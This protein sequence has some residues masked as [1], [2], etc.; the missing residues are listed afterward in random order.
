MKLP[1][2][3]PD[4]LLFNVWLG[5]KQALEFNTEYIDAAAEF[6][7]TV[8]P[9][10][11]FLLHLYELSRAAEDV[12]TYAHAGILKERCMALDPRTR[13]IIPVPNHPYSLTP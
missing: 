9:G 3:R 5:R 2:V 1:A 6:I 10:V 12:W 11:T 7:C 8:N 4:V 13:I